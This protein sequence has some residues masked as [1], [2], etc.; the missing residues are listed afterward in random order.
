MNQFACNFLP[1]QLWSALLKTL[2]KL[3]IIFPFFFPSSGSTLVTDVDQRLHVTSSISRTHSA[4]GVEEK[5]QDCGNVPYP[6][7][8]QICVYGP[9]ESFPY[10]FEPLRVCQRVETSP[11]HSWKKKSTG[12]SCQR[13]GQKEKDEH[14]R[15]L[16]CWTNGAN[17]AGT[18]LLITQFTNAT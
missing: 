2:N 3:L 18:E 5:S 11:Q 1:H 16:W 14:E 9:R 4:S 15:Q 10:T 7:Q 17:Y 12:T 6:L 8:F 13:K